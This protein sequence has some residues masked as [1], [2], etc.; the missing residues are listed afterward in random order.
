MLMHDEPKDRFVRRA[1]LALLLLSIMGAAL[2]VQLHSN[3]PQPQLMDIVIPPTFMLAFAAQ[4]FYLY[5]RPRE[6]EAV[7]RVTFLL[8]FTALLVPAWFY[9]LRAHFLPDVSLVETLPPIVP[10]LFPVSIGF[11]LFLRPREVAPA[12]VAAWALIGGPIL[13]YLLLHSEEMFTPRGTDLLIALLP[14]MAIVY[15]MLQFH[16]RMRSG[17]GRL[18]AETSL[19]KT[20]AHRDSLTGLYNRRAGDEFLARLAET[21]VASRG[22][23]MFDIDNFK[24]IN[25][26]HGHAVGDAVLREVAR[27]CED[28]L[29]RQDYLVR[30]GGEEFLAILVDADEQACRNVAETLREMI[31]RQSFGKAGAV[32]ASFGIAVLESQESAVDALAHADAA[33]YCAKANGRNRVAVAARMSSRTKV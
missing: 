14:A 19:L 11:V 30:W 18:E 10:L 33:L 12:V 25:D 13:G 29:R 24:D 31:A 28:R 23:V 15:V 5:R 7:L 8:A 27:C 26:T 2:A 16:Q 17:L 20:L 22:L 1:S 4:L 21:R 9:S 3:A 32:T 6:V